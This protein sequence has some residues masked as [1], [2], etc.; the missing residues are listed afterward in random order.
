LPLV[1]VIAIVVVQRR[2]SAG[3]GE[4]N[5]DNRTE[6]TFVPTTTMTPYDDKTC[7]IE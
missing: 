6:D 4:D 7:T 2:F 5:G 1:V 3:R